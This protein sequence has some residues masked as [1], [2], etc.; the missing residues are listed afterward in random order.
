MEI[1]NV[2]SGVCSI[3]GLFVSLIVANKV[4]KISSSISSVENSYN[5]IKQSAKGNNNN[6]SGRDNNVR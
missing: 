1:F 5:K 3:L 2:I 6:Q 4:I